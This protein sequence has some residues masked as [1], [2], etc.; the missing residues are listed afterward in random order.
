MS[1]PSANQNSAS[2]DRAQA[3]KVLR[4]RVASMRG[5]ALLLILPGIGL[6]IWWWFFYSSAVD[7]GLQALKAAHRAGR[8]I[9]ARLSGFDYAPFVSLRGARA[10]DDK[11]QRLA[12][13]L[14]L[15]VA[16][17]KP[18]AE[19][20]RA[21]G[22]FYLAERQWD[23]A[24]EAF[25]RGTQMNAQDARLQSDLGAALFEKGRSL[26]ASDEDGSRVEAFALSL[27]HLNRA[28]ALDPDLHE[29]IFNRA[30]LGQQMVL[31]ERATKDWRFYIEKDPNSLWADEVRQHLAEIEERSSE[32][33]Q[34]NLREDFLNAYRVRDAERVW[35]LFS[36]NRETLIKDLLDACLNKSD[37]KDEASRAF[38]ALTYAGELDAQRTGDQFAFDLARFYKSASTQQ[39][40]DALE[41]RELISKAYKMYERSHLEEAVDLYT[42]AE[43]IFSRIGNRCEARRATYRLGVI[44]LEMTQTE[45]GESLFGSLARDCQEDSYRWLEARALFYRSG[46]EFTRHEF[47]K[48]ISSAKRAR[49]QA[50]K[51]NDMQ[52]VLAAT[53]ALIEYYRTLENQ[54][55]CF[56]EISF[57]LSLLK[58]PIF[59]PVSLGRHYGIT[60]MTFN[61]FG[62]YD[63]AIDYQRE[64]LR[65]ALEMDDYASLSLSHAH[66]G[67]MYGKL[68][69]FD[70]AFKVINRSYT[71]AEEHG[72]KAAGQEK[73]AYSQLQMGN[74]YKETGDFTNA[75]TSYNRSI[76]FYKSMN[77]P[78]HLYQAYKGRLVC[79]IEQND[80]RAVEQ[81]ADELMILMDH[82]REKIFEEENRNNYFDTEQS[83]YDL[84]IDFWHSRLQDNRKAF[85][86][87]EASRARSLLYSIATVQANRKGKF[88]LQMPT[89]GRPFSLELILS[90]IPEEARLLQYAVLQ[91]KLLVWIISRHGFQVIQTQVSEAELTEKISN[92]TDSIGKPLETESEATSQLA[93]ELYRHLIAPV[94]SRLDG[95]RRLYVVPDKALHNVPWDAL[96]SPATGRYL[97]EDYVVMATPSATLFAICTE[98]AREKEGR[99]D[100]RGVIVGNPSFDSQAFPG[101]DPLPDA[102]REAEKIADLY[103]SSTK[104]IGPA[105]RE[106]AVRGEMVRADIAH[107]AS[108]ADINEHSAMRSSLLLAREP[109]SGAKSKSIDGIL[110][111]SEIY[112]MKLPRMRVAVL[113]ACQTGVERYYRGEGRIGMA[114]AFIVAGVPV[115]VASLWPVD[116]KPTAELMIRFHEYRKLSH[117]PTDEALRRAKLDLLQ[118]SVKRYR[119]P[120]YWAAFQ[121]IGGDASF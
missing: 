80:V 115:V 52:C 91:D 32:H 79:Y 18:S 101:F 31:P 75:L 114:R 22:C 117:L 92:Y 34:Q 49:A 37:Q 111:A 16:I 7:K 110:Q 113:A 104:L 61:T 26:S 48:A 120:F 93:R 46:I 51:S 57:S 59:A 25:R 66:L 50:D 60:A 8:L 119:H 44:Y 19:A 97:V 10:D 94:E 17:E 56:R 109:E 36:L 103:R 13:R 47:S 88:N 38:D 35:T 27:S 72:D 14:L 71:Q 83:V 45:K 11:E 65:F 108:H 86:Y 53:S 116:S 63:A 55:E 62:L 64:A 6:G 70:E 95:S 68:Q 89:G 1:K 42:K 99:R 4:Q 41:A 30:L 29:A 12:E 20:W 28:L 40:K 77:F 69:N 74:L 21:M 23:R 9:E 100:E 102:E 96:V 24:I 84:V 81:Q 54:Y 33:A 78:M 39:L 73:M 87:V 3:G 15:D 90:R 5:R 107:F 105:A 67:R 82:H 98:M 106:Q 118:R 121:S 2:E 58:L 112:E 43:S 85:E 76:D